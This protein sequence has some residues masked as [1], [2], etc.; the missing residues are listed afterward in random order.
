[1]RLPI[2][3]IAKAK[4]EKGEMEKQQFLSEFSANLELRRRKLRP[5]IFHKATKPKEN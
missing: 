3:M 5:E 4:L 2:L 1:M